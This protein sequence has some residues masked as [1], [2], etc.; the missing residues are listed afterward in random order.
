MRKLRPSLRAVE[1]TIDFD[2]IITDAIKGHKGKARK[3][4]LAGAWNAAWAATAR[5]LG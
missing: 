2:E 4:K 3:N 1:N 5:K